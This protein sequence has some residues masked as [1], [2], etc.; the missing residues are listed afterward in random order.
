MFLCRGVTTNSTVIKARFKE[1]TQVKLANK[2]SLF[3]KIHDRA[4]I[5]LHVVYILAQL[6][7]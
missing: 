1:D 6:A 4:R 3:S 2:M 5:V 7:I